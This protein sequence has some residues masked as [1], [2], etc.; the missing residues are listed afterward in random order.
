MPFFHGRDPAYEKEDAMKLLHLSDLHLGKRVGE[1]SLLEDQRDMLQ[2]LLQV[3]RAFQVDA[4]LL[5][6]DLYDKPIPPA[7]AVRLLDEFLTELSRLGIPVLAISGN[8]D[9][10]ERLDFATR[11]LDRE[12]IHLAARY[13][14]PRPPVRLEDEYGPVNFYLLPYL[15]P[16]LVRHQYPEEE[17]LTYA[18]AVAWALDQWQVDP[19]GRNVLLAHQFVT[20]GL[21]CESE[22][23]SVGGLD[24]IPGE[25]FAPFDYVALG[26]LHGPQWVGRETVRYCGSPLKYSFSESRQEKS[27][28]LVTLGQKGDVMVDLISLTPL[29]D[30]REVRGSYE[31]VTAR[32]FYQG[33]GQEDYLH[34]ILTD[35]EEIPGA[36]GKLR[37]IYP[38][39]LKLSYDNLRTQ[40]TE[41]VTGALRPEER[42]PLD[43]FREFYQLQNNQPMGQAQ[44]EFLKHLM[45]EIWEGEP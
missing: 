34:V 20:G 18:Q 42:S 44:E 43:L 45:E 25:L 6:G 10:P 37:V 36:A 24:Q 41:E 5:A 35:E 39:L 21:T 31:E 23:L 19:A 14:G 12:G 26:H 29:R 8:H 13:Q 38:N 22:E 9:S 4:L 2:K 28:T 16:V 1:V 17:F 11:L 15:K 3:A 32:S 7:Q 27:A 33:G 40:S 30:M